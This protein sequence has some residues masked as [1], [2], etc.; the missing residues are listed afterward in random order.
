[1]VWEMVKLGAMDFLIGGS[2]IVLAALAVVFV[3]GPTGAFIAIAGAIVGAV[4]LV[5]GSQDRRG[6]M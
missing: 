6:P 3:S 2:A 5:K 4:F 1:M